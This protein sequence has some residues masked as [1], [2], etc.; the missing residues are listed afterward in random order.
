MRCKDTKKYLNTD[1]NRFIFCV[2]L[3]NIDYNHMGLCQNRRSLF[4]N[5]LYNIKLSPDFRKPGLCHVRKF[6]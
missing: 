4:C 1:T 5:L 3:F 2:Y 6:L